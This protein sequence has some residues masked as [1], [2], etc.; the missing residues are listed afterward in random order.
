MEMTI[1][2]LR[3]RYYRFRPIRE[4]LLM[5]LKDKATG[6]PILAGCLFIEKGLYG[7]LATPWV[8]LKEDENDPNN[9]WDNDVAN[10]AAAARNGGNNNN[11]VMAA[12]CGALYETSKSRFVKNKDDVIIGT[13]RTLESKSM[14]R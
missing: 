12:G 4:E 9:P 5:Y 13:M 8:I 7:D 3:S 1:S 11:K 14:N 10:R 6:N 2:Q